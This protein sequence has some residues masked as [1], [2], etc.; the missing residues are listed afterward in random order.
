MTLDVRQVHAGAAHLADP[1]IGRALLV[2]TA[3][4]AWPIPRPDGV[5]AGQEELDTIAPGTTTRTRRPAVDAGRPDR[6]DERAVRPAVMV[7]HGA[8]SRRLRLGWH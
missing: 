2:G 3:A 4:T 7:E 5:R 8:P 6:V 1:R